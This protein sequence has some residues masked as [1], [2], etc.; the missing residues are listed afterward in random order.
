MDRRQHSSVG[1]RRTLVLLGSV[2]V[3]C[4]A[5]LPV[6]VDW[7]D[8]PAVVVLSLG[9]GDTLSYLRTLERP[10]DDAIRL[11][12]PSDEPNATTPPAARPERFRNVR[13]S[14]VPDASPAATACN[15]GERSRLFLAAASLLLMSI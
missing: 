7:P 2:T 14:S 4:T 11:T 6:H 13:R 3:G 8:A 15:R 1:L 9:S 10:P 5:P 12:L